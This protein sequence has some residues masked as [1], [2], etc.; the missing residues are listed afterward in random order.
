MK[1]WNFIFV[2][3]IFQKIGWKGQK[4]IFHVMHFMDDPLKKDFCFIK[5]VV[6]RYSLQL[7]LT[8]LFSVVS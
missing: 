7:I 5:V 2:Q 3:G 6:T 8:Q 1:K 4:A